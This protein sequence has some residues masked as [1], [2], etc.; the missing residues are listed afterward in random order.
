MKW[1]HTALIVFSSVA[2]AVAALA[3]GVGLLARK[4]GVWY[5]AAGLYAVAVVP[6]VLY[7]LWS[8]LPH[9]RGDR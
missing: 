9:Q 7:L 6:P 4:P 1:Y 2:G 8:G 5:P 3:V